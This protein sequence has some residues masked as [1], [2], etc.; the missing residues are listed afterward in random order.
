MNFTLSRAQIDD[1]IA[2]GA[3]SLA[4]FAGVRDRY[5]NTFNSHTLGRFGEIAVA[6]LFE[7]EGHSVIPHYRDL[8]SLKLCDV[9]VAGSVPY[10]RLEVKTWGLSNWKDLGRCIQ[11]GQIGKIEQ[12]ADAIV[13]CTVPLPYLR[14]AGDLVNYQTLIVDLVGFSL[15]SDVKK[16]PICLTG[17]PNTRQV[18]NYQVPQTELRNASGL[19]A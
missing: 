4:R 17:R 12:A 18:E 3:T 7:A 14:S 10:Q 15:P 6:A 11:V 2:L 9:E 1:A 19:L 16:A 5:N 13:W 8:A